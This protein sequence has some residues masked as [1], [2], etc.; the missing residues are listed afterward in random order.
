MRR[1]QSSIAIRRFLI[2]WTALIGIVIG[3]CSDGE[4]ADA[5]QQNLTFHS[6]ASPLSSFKFDTGLIPP[7]SPAQVQL[8]LALGGGMKLDNV[9]AASGAE[10]V[11]KE[12]GKLAID[13]RL[14]LDGRLKIDTPLKKVDEELPGLKSVDFAITGSSDVNSLLLEK[15]ETAEVSANATETKLPEIP[16][17]SVPGSLTLTILKDT[18]IKSKVHGTCVEI[19]GGKAIYRGV[20]ETSGTLA[21]KGTLAVKL[22]AP[23]DKS[24]DLPVI[25]APIPATTTPVES[26]PV[27]VPGM[28]DGK[29]GEC[30]SGGSTP[31]TPG[32]DGSDPNSNPDG[33]TPP[34]T[35]AT[36]NTTD[37][38]GALSAS[39]PVTYGGGAF[40]NYQMVFSNIRMEIRRSTTDGTIL[41]ASVV[42][43]ATETSPGMAC[44]SP[45]IPANG[46]A[47]SLNP[48]A[49]QTIDAGVR[50]VYF[51]P[52]AANQ[53][54]A[55]LRVE[56]SSDGRNAKLFFRR[57]DAAAP[58]LEW[59]MT[60]S[61]VLF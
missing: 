27:D 26:T 23:L 43:T 40:C 30:A 47:Y 56:L 36:P 11:G 24:V 29:Q 48:A 60:E 17:G 16:L 22:P 44:S 15:D 25:T 42:A 21:L 46:H 59:S 31:N 3:A 39:Q 13:F 7:A 19:K 6:E 32:A 54:K 50:N 38:K 53:P 61:L 4:W 58:A 9:G 10:I 57:T 14:K 20:A 34:L 49:L 2:C 5:N 37:L 28:A 55:S 41:A 35:D 52:A 18:V 33:S 1:R 8:K 45:L 51:I 12:G